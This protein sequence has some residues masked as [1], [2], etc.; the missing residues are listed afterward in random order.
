MRVSVVVITA[1]TTEY[2]GECSRDPVVVEKDYFD[3]SEEITKL[4]YFQNNQVMLLTY[5][6]YYWLEMSIGLL[7]I[8]KYLSLKFEIKQR[9]K[10]VCLGVNM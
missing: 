5:L 9:V 2:S 7:L 4:D 3:V 10:Q 8:L 1:I 6:W